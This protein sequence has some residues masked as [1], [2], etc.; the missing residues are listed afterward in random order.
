MKEIHK[1]IL[2]DGDIE[3]I[4]NLRTETLCNNCINRNESY[5]CFCPEERKRAEEVEPYK[6][7]PYWDLA[8]KYN[9]C[10]ELKNKIMYLQS[11]IN[12]NKKE[13]DDLQKEL[14]ELKIIDKE[15]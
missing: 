15:N 14:I 10:Q 11:E 2:E 3:I 1:I 6:N 5:C 9:K 8:E 4:K 7:T 12:N 13:L